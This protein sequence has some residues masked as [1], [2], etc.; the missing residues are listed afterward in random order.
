MELS[1][2]LKET[3]A[4]RARG[5]RFLTHAWARYRRQK[6]ERRIDGFLR[7]KDGRAGDLPSGVVYEATMRCNLKCEFCYVGD[8]LNVE[9]EWREEMPIDVL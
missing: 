4:K 1:R 6:Y 2:R 7:A 3:V 8:L 5:V 9:G